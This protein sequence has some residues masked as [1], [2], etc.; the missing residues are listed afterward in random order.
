MQPHKQDGGREREGLAYDGRSPT[1]ARERKIKLPM[2]SF[3]HLSPSVCNSEA[4]EIV[5]IGS[6]PVGVVGLLHGVYKCRLMFDI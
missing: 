2:I 4:S 1:G 6:H 3:Q 5:D